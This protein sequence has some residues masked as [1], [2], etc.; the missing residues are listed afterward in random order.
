MIGNAIK[1]NDMEIR[2]RIF[3]KDV[4]GMCDYAGDT[5]DDKELEEKVLTQI[6]TGE[7]PEPQI[8]YRSRGW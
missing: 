6:A 8:V 4:C 1:M 5:C 7:K 2:H 3:H